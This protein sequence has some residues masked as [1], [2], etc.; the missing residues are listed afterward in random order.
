MKE[1]YMQKKIIITE[2]EASWIQCIAQDS[3]ESSFPVMSCRRVSCYK[4]LTSPRTG[5]FPMCSLI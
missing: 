2:R 1:K 3:D 4:E 5:L